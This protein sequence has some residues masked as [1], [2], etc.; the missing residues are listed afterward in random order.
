MLL[1]M[2]L[3]PTALFQFQP[4][5]TPQDAGLQHERSAEGAPQRIAAINPNQM[6]RAFSA[7]IYIGSWFLGRC[8]T[9]HVKRAVGAKD[10]HGLQAHAIVR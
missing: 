6:N 10:K 5:A 4:G 7:V 8:P 3:A 1:S 9:L 2:C